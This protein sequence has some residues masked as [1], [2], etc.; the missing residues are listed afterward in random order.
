MKRTRATA[1]ATSPQGNHCSSYP[2]T[3]L[4]P[5]LGLALISAAPESPYVD[6][7]SVDVST[8]GGGRGRGVGHCVSACLADID[9]RGGDLQSSAGHLQTERTLPSREG[10][11]RA[12]LPSPQG[13]IQIHS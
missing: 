7:L 11:G 10:P 8:D 13:G 4:A 2:G 6:G 9:L 5:G 1:T 12:W 3:L